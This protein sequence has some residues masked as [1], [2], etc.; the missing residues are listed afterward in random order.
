[1]RI[2]KQVFIGTLL[3]ILVFFSISFLTVLF[4]IHSPINRELSND[5]K[6]GFP[7]TYYHEFIVDCPY[8]NSGWMVNNLSLD[9]IFT[10]LIVTIVYV[11]LQKIKKD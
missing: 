8:P 10:W 1:M 4:Q 6:I 5:L 3:S 11:G 9:C 7:Y 2:I